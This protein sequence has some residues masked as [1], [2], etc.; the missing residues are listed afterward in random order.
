MHYEIMR[1]SRLN[2][3]VDMFWTET[4][5]EIQKSRKFSSESTEATGKHENMDY[6]ITHIYEQ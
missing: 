2:S 6:R 4:E 3:W 5:T 1:T